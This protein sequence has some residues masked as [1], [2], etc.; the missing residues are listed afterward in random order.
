MLP[1]PGIDK[2]KI[3][4]E[5]CGTP[6][7][8][9]IIYSL[10]P[11]LF[12]QWTKVYDDVY[13]TTDGP[14]ITV[15]N[16]SISGTDFPKIEQFYR[17]PAKL[18]EGNVLIGVCNSLQRVSLVPYPFQGVGISGAK[19]PRPFWGWVC[20]YVQWHGYIQVEGMSRGGGY[21]QG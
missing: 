5:R 11:D 4:A 18:R 9:E 3:V 2:N 21:V 7:K 17:Q 13:N 15:R 6:P 1:G 12:I 8:K 19:L 10:E 16:A 14:S 20:P